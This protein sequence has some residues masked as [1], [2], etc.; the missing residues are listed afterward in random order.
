MKRLDS[1]DAQKRPT[2]G[3]LAGGPSDVLH[4]REAS[5]P[6]LT[7]LSSIEILYISASSSDTSGG[8]Y[9]VF[10]ILSSGWFRLPTS[11]GVLSSQLAASFGGNAIRVQCALPRKIFLNPPL[12][13]FP[14]RIECD[15][16]GHP[17]VL[18]CFQLR[19]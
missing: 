7:P 6:G 19:D 2:G 14:R 1:D 15:V 8:N 13:Y 3:S 10:R 5:A 11:F 18:G 9:E 17:L 16:C 4:D 12:Q